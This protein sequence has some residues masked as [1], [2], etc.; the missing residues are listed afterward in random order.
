MRDLGATR[1]TAVLGAC[2]HAECYAFGPVELDAIAAELGEDVRATTSAGKPALD[3]PAGVRR[4][5]ATV[6]VDDVFEIGGCTAC[7]ENFFSH[8]A[9]ADTGRHLLACWRP[10]EV[11]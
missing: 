2:I 4:S 6:G 11:A 8:R 3:L 10:G 7:A 5:L 9:R 1:C